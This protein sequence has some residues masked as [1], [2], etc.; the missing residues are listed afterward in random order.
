MARRLGIV[1][2]CSALFAAAELSPARAATTQLDFDDLAAGTTLGSMSG[3]T[4]LGSP[5][6]FNP[7]HVGTISEP[8]AVHPPGTCPG[9]GI[10][11]SGAN[12]LEVL[13]DNPAASVSW[14]VGLDDQ[15]AGEFGANAELVGYDAGGTPVATSGPKD[16]G[17]NGFKPI[18][19]KVEVNSSGTD[20]VRAVLTGGGE[21]LRMNADR[22]VF[23]DDVAPVPP[24]PT[25]TLTSPP[26]GGTYDR[27][28]DIRAGGSVNA[29]AGILRFCVTV[30]PAPPSDFPAH[31]PDRFRLSAG[32]TTGT[33]TNLRAGP[34][35]TGTNYVTAWVEDNRFRTA[36]H[37]IGVTLRDSDLSVT[38]MEITQAIQGVLPDPQ[39]E[40]HDVAHTADYNGVPLT[41]FKQTAVRVWTEARLDSAGSPIPGAAVHL[42]GFRTN[43]SRLPGGPLVPLE[44]VRA[45][46]ESLSFSRPI[47]LAPWS[48]PDTSWTFLLPSSW[49]NQDGPI[50]LRATVNPPTAFPPVNECSGCEANNS[51]TLRGVRFTPGRR[52]SIFPF[53]AFYRKDGARRAPPGNP[54]GSAAGPAA[55]FADAMAASPFFFD[56]RPYRGTL[57]V[58][59]IADSNP[60]GK[61]ASDEI[62][63]R[64]TDAID[65]AGYPGAHTIAIV[66][67]LANGVNSDH[68]SWS[69]LTVRNY[70]VVNSDRPLTSVAH[71]VYHH[72][73]FEHAGTNCSGAVAG[74]G[75]ADWPP[76]ERGLLQ[77]VGTDV[78]PAYR[79]SALKIFS[80]G[81]RDAA[82]N[83]IE[84]FDF[85]SYCAGESNTWI[86][87]RNWSAA[88]ARVS[89]AVRRP[90]G[91]PALARSAQAGGRT[92]AINA[93]VLPER[94]R[95]GSVGP[96]GSRLSTPAGDGSLRIVVRD[97]AGQ[98][99]SDLP[100]AGQPGVV[101]GDPT[102]PGS[103]MTRVT[104]V[105]PARGAQS[106]ELVRAGVVLDV[107]T[108]SSRAPAVALRAPGRK[109][110]VR[111]RQRSV[112]V[113]WRARD[114]DGDP[115]N[116]ILEYS[117]D[118]GRRWRGVAA[119]LTRSSFRLPAS[120]LSHAR[121]ARLRLRAND[122]WNESVAVSRPFRV[123]GPP[124]AVTILAPRPGGRIPADQVINVEGSAFDDR[125]RRLG[126]RALRWFDGRR[127]IGRGERTSVLLRPGRRS[128]R[129]RARDRRGRVQ[130]ARARVRVIPVK[131][132]F[133]VLGA[134]ARIRRKA[135]FVRLRVASS[136]V[137]T[138]A[139]G[140]QRFPV[141]RRARRYRVRVRRGRKPVVLRP[142]LRSGGR[143]TRAVVRIRRR[144]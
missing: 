55:V 99:L 54:L 20:I 118:N 47:G 122:G 144:R 24:P 102:A 94:G 82:L 83:L 126:R 138:L 23:T 105:V 114:G 80:R 135:R 142:R 6:V 143:S 45:I 108:R 95:I 42:Q 73:G 8:H 50:M 13:F 43:G 2:L 123:D 127:Q 112:R 111:S 125:G 96:G 33:F 19:T 87:V 34:F 1:V 46:G 137:G 51:L 72:L 59:S 68:F 44:G 69:S 14:Y 124:P 49:T 25:V 57:N 53:Q 113:R 131:P 103:S 39:P 120:F 97:A 56:V 81:Q 85:M 116:L 107:R 65:I 30:T 136:V 121:R 36:R 139:V 134:P 75:A 117:D 130:Q 100:V 115:L 104:A 22:L 93:T 89:S 60:S 52:L 16:L 141:D 48:K 98:V 76:D 129:L 132:R 40:D 84:N 41:R 77:G 92:V 38:N 119:G 66:K 7:V 109:T 58:Q 28:D 12:R 140:R 15:S 17:F 128:L 4:F 29:P 18:T 67:G 35:V 86:S 133:V 71:E 31:C 90:A 91:A 21:A 5:T 11:P 26:D 63:D 70:S 37:T 62:Y 106:V 3:V 78:R 64:L 110:R 9:T 88:N 79:G 74:G 101:D 32:D 27:I 10:C 61:E